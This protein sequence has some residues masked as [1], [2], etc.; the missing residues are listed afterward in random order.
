MIYDA[1]PTF[2]LSTLG[3]CNR[4]YRVSSYTGDD[5]Y[6]DREKSNSQMISADTMGI[7]TL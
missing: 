6:P 1:Q 3:W 2:Q 4:P 5:D 7:Q